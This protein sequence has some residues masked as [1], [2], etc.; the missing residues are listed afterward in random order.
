MQ[1]LDAGL[2]DL[3]AVGYKFAEPD[4][5]WQFGQVSKVFTGEPVQLFSENHVIKIISIVYVAV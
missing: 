4:V 3:I 1:H 2:D 5:C